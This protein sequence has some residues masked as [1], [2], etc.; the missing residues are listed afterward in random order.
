MEALVDR[1]GAELERRDAHALAQDA[2]LRRL[3]TEVDGLRR[4]VAACYRVLMDHGL[5]PPEAAHL[6]PGS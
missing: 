3:R 1:L 4:L 6:D 2:E 5:E